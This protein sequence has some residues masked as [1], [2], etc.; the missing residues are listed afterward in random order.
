MGKLLLLLSCSC[1]LL[2]LFG[3]AAFPDSPGFWLASAAP[4]YEHVR[5]LL[6]FVL[7][8]QLVTRPP[9]HLAFRVACGI[10]AAAVATWA[11]QETY[12]AQMLLLDSLSLLAAATAIGVTALEVSTPQ[13]DWLSHFTK[14][15][16]RA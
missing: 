4:S 12:A 2:L 1:L 13:P 5:S 8:V 9:R 11:I 3:T 15:A 10:V 6:A 14:R 7:L 16:E